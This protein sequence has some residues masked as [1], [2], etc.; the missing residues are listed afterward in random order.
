MKRFLYV[1]LALCVTIWLLGAPAVSANAPAQTGKVRVGILIAEPFVI[2]VTDHYAGYSI[3]YWEKLAGELGVTY[4]YV[5]LETSDAAVA[6]IENNSIDLLIGAI[7]M[8]AERERVFD[9]THAY[10]TSGL[11]I[12]TRP[13]HEQSFMDSFAPLIGTAVLRVLAVAFLFAVVMAHVI[14]FIERRHNPQFQQGYFED[15]WE[16]F[17]YLL[18]IVATGEYGDKEA[19]TP[20]K[21]IVTVAFWLMGVIFIAQFTATATSNLTVQQLNS[22]IQGPKDLPGKRVVTLEGSVAADFLTSRN[23][24]FKAV[25]QIQEAYVLLETGEADAVVTQAPLLQYY[26]SHAGSGRVEVVG[27]V[28]GHLPI[29]IALPP[30]SKLL[31]PL[32]IAILKFYEDGMYAEI[33]AK[34]FGDETK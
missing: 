32:N 13:P 6:A 5:P 29:G 23:I 24:P 19:R 34:W 10:F 12:L 15:I 1:S 22:G 9:L 27:P 4:E 7:G 31:E 28:F 2:R 26:A 17:W 20:I 33:K 8:T 21:R 14:Y 30:G 3:D 18:I 11:Q 25:P 16:A